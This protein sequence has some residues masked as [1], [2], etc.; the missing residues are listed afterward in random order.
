M[1]VLKVERRVVV[2]AQH[3]SRRM[4]P[5]GRYDLTVQISVANGKSTVVAVVDFKAMEHPWKAVNRFRH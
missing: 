2:L 1:A 3:S 4:E 5:M